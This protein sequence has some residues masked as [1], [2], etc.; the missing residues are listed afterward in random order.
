MYIVLVFFVLMSMFIALI[1]EAYEKA[2]HA[3]DTHI[4]TKITKSVAGY[5]EWS[6]TGRNR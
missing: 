1:S 4:S 5:G 3:Q 2:R 6:D